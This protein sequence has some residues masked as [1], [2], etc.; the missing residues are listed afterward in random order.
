MEVPQKVTGFAPSELMYGRAVR[1]PMKILKELWTNESK[2]LEVKTS[3]QYVFVL[4]KKFEETIRLVQY[5]KSSEKVRA[6]TNN[7]DRKAKERAFKEGDKVLVMLP[8]KNNNKLL[9]CSSRGRTKL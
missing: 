9:G 1:G 4:K 5:K 7:Y 2:E 6:D 8:T 3:Y